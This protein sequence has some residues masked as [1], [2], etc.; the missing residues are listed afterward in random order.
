MASTEL[1]SLTRTD[2][3]NPAGRL[4][5]LSWCAFGVIA[6]MIVLHQ[7]LLQPTISNLI[8]DAPAI[9]IAG[10]QRMLSQK[11][12]KAALMFCADA[13]S[14]AEK[15]ARRQQLQLTL[16][17]WRTAHEHLRRESAAAHLAHTQPGE[18]EIG[19]RKLQPRFEAMVTAADR[20]LSGG[21]SPPDLTALN[22]LLQNEPEF[23]T[24][25]HAIVGMYEEGT[26]I[27]VRQLQGLGIVIM[28]VILA[29]HIVM[30]LAIVRPAVRIVGNE[31]EQ[32]EMKYEQLVESMTDG[33]VVFDPSGR[34]DFANR[35]FGA[36]LGY[37]VDDLIDKPAAILIGD[38]DRRRFSDMLVDPVPGTEP[39][40]LL[41]KHAEGRLVETLTSPQ[42]L[43]DHSG[44][45]Q[46]L[47]LVVTDVT[48]RRA[49]EERSRQLMDQLTHADR[50][51]SMGAMAAAMAHE[52][53]QPLGAIANYAEGCLTRLSG[54][55]VQPDDLV[56]PLE[57]ILRATHRGA[58]I[59]RR[60]RDFVRL[61]PHRISFEPINHLVHE[62][63]EL[64]RPEARRRGTSLELQLASDLPDIPVDSIQIQ[65]VLINL[66][67]NAFVA[68]EHVEI[69]RRRVRMTTQ[70]SDSGGVEISVADTGPG[71]PAEGAEAWF[72]PF[73]TTRDE[74]MGMGL[75]IVRGIVEAHGGRIWAEPGP[76]GGAVLRFTLPS[77]APVVP[78]HTATM[79]AVC[80]G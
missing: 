25:M 4:D 64:C 21:A 42:S 37:P 79:E 63:E 33:L 57:R 9:N 39:V 61:R 73:M 26:R 50:L 35:R 65:Q 10:R 72:E 2:R 8:S 38:A 24:L 70:L 19:F 58:E 5:R 22:S 71:V 59:I 80:H 6:A 44:E 46:G 11:L 15:D 18:I 77:Q 60:S 36:M 78:D 53:N 49:M 75:A 20:L 41:L 16:D 14:P 12:A 56:A 31:I 74:G 34:I 7:C 67:Q 47:L 28:V 23:L 76:D 17:E 3:E 62:V 43:R 69:F 52:I 13:A 32:S 68:V 27:H 30:Q 48:A 45:R 55:E 40:D 1:H 51:K 29:A 66:I 54:S